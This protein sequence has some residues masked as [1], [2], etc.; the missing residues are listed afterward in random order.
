MIGRRAAA[1]LW[2]AAAVVVWNAVFDRVII[3]AGRAYVKTAAEAAQGTGPY[4]RIDDSMRPA[5]PRALALATASAGAVLAA[6]F[7]AH[8]VRAARSTSA[9]RPRRT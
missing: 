5:L 8:R 3:N 1:A 2:L 6:G 9:E 4:A 7:V